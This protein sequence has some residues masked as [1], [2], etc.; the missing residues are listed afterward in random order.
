MA[1]DV[2]RGEAF[3]TGAPRKLFSTGIAVTFDTGQSG[4]FETFYNV[5]ADGERFLIAEPLPAQGAPSG[6]GAPDESL[7]VIVNWTSGLGTK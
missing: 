1:V 4:L 3:E 7:H 6:V 2:Q 5:S